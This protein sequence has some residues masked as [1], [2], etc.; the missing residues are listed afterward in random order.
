[1]TD[2]IGEATKKVIDLDAL[3]KLAANHVAALREL[4]RHNDKGI[5]YWFRPKAME[6]LRLCGFAEQ[7]T[8][9]SVEERPRMKKRPWRI[10][11]AG[12]AFLARNGKG[13]G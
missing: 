3:E 6:R 9:R 2:H 5:C 4:E 12:R 13:G 8:P 1:M 11:D 7:W 10:T